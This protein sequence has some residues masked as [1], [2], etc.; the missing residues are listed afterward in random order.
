M[1]LESQGH[2][3]VMY[4]EFDRDTFFHDRVA[5]RKTPGYQQLLKARYHRKHFPE[6]TLDFFYVLF[7]APT[8]TR[9]RQLRNAFTRKNANDP[10]LKIYRFG[11]FESLTPENLLTTPQFRCCHHD[12]LVPLV[13]QS[14]PTDHAPTAATT[15][16]QSSGTT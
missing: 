4:I 6:T 8:D 12:D 2:Q 14:I 3:A 1:V 10:A 9:A 16:L 11:S 15:P 13:K 5:A 7:I